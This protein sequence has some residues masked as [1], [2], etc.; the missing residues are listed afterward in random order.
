MKS[1]LKRLLR[2]A[3]TPV[4][5]PVAATVDE[6]LRPF[7]EARMEH[8]EDRFSWV[9]DRVREARSEVAAVDTRLDRLEGRVTTDTQ[10]TTE[11]TAAWQRA[12]GRLAAD[13]DL[14]R[15]LLLQGTDSRVAD[16]VRRAAAGG[17]P[18]ADRDLAAFVLAVAPGAADRVVAAHEG[19]ALAALGSGTADFLNW[20]GGHEGP[21]GQAGVWVNHPVTVR[22]A[23]GAVEPGDVNERIVEIPYALA[24]VAALPAGAAVLDFGA[25]E[26]TLSLSLASLGYDVTAVD[27]R[28]YPF[29]HPNLRTVLEPVESWAGPPR[30]F[31]AI[32]SVSTLE[33][34]GLGHYG[35]DAGGDALDARIVERF[36]GWLRPGGELV[37]TAP[38]G[39]WS[40]DELQRTYDAAHLEALL[41]GWRVLDR[42]VC[43]QTA[44]DRWERCDGEPSPGTWAAG[45]RGVVL[46]RATP[47]ARS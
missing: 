24:A 16:L 21:A 10:T 22:H 36:A 47:D 31:D 6:R 39:A 1:S 7:I 37:L 4:A 32:L 44:P 30:P 9:E 14:V 27:L 2:T 35:H 12:A 8:L 17:D 19:V 45:A 18:E 25:A 13:L 15:G 29:A 42:V 40:I 11:L 38:Y 41:A 23:A 33:H 46:L 20:A 5:A 3:A 28:P 43:V 34:V 26:S